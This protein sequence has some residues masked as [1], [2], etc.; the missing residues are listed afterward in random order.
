MLDVYDYL[1]RGDASHDPR[2]QSGDVVFVPIRG[3]TVRVVGEINRPATYE[4][5]VGESLSDLVRAAGGF[6]PTAVTSRAHDR[7]LPAPQRRDGGA[8]RV[9]HRRHDRPSRTA[10]GDG[11]GPDTVQVA[12]EDGDVVRVFAI[13]DRVGTASRSWATC[14][15]RVRRGSHRG[16]AS[17]DAIA[18]AGGLR[19][20]AYSARCS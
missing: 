12:L 14:G 3:A 11:G 18:R 20:D 10:S 19:A 6:R 4:L 16:F 17:P 8:A 5:S 9:A 13:P 7:I 15:S 2:L 1:L